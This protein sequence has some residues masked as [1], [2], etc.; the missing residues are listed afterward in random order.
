MESIRNAEC[1]I[2]PTEVKKKDENSAP[3]TAN[4]LRKFGR[5][6]AKTFIHHHTVFPNDASFTLQREENSF[7]SLLFS[8]FNSGSIHKSATE[9]PVI[10]TSKKSLWYNCCNQI[11]GDLVFRTKERYFGEFVQEI[12]LQHRDSP[13]VCNSPISGETS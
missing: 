9:F 11:R 13:I 12:Q 3:L 1:E 10:L 6:A 8:A 4:T 2:N 7:S 5:I